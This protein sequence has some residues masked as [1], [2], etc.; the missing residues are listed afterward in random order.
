MFPIVCQ[1]ASD[2]V[3]AEAFKVSEDDPQPLSQEEEDERVML[4]EK[5]FQNWTRYVVDGVHKR[6]Y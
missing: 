2:D 3:V 5:G 1:G 6:H 4:L